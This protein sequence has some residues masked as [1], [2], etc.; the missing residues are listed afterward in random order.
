MAQGSERKNRTLWDR[1]GG[2]R[3]SLR[4][5]KK[6]TARGKKASKVCVAASRYLKA[7]TRYSS[8]AEKNKF[9]ACFVLVGVEGRMMGPGKKYV[10]FFFVQIIGER[11]Q[12]FEIYHRVSQSYKI[13]R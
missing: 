12:S 4:T 7:G 5:G 11:F 9:V 2:G 3:R 10:F 6:P 13:F 1:L 8:P